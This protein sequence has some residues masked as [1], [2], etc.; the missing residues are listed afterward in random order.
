MIIELILIA[1]IVVLAI[2]LYFQVK[3]THTQAEEGK[4]LLEDYQNRVNEQEKLLADYRTLEKNF[5]DV[6]AGYDQALLMFDKMEENSRTLE[7]SNKKLSENNSKLLDTHARVAEM[8]QKKNELIQQIA[9]KLRNAV[10][11]EPGQSTR[12]IETRIHNL[13]NELL[14]LSDMDSE[15][16]VECDDNVMVPQ[17]VAQAVEE[18][19]IQQADFFKFTSNVSDIAAATM[20]LTNQALAIRVL[21]NLLD[22]AKKFTTGGSVSLS[23]DIQDSVISFAVENAG[24]EIAADDAERIFEPFVKLN[25]YFDGIG[26]GLTA[27]RNMARRLN[28]DVVLDTTFT[29]GARFVFTLPV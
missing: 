1:A 17:M 6:G 10:K 11:L 29:G 21:E 25:S 9:D 12:L 27:A 18:S 22:N 23:A 4:K 14:N 13:T 5:E 2:A 26:I 20:L 16:A 19:G 24:S 15:T 3:A 28:G 7:E 8:A